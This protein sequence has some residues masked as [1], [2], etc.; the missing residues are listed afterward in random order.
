[1]FTKKVSVRLLTVAGATAL[2]LGVT[3]GTQAGTATANLTVQ[4]T[5]TSNC[6]IT[7]TAVD[8]G[9]YDP[10]VANASAALDAPAGGKV[11]LVCS[12][13]A[14]AK[15][16]LSEGA[17]PTGGSTAAAPARRLKHGTTDYLTYTLY[18]DA[19]K[20]N[21]WGDTAGTGLAHTGTGAQADLDVYGTVDGGQNVPV[22]TYT[23]TVVATVTF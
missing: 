17:N 22:G 5:V 12:N 18:S 6:T 8:F 1:M 4:A 14:A 21:V 15:V 10:I 19:G 23:D 20:Q 9:N 3:S 7:T 2:A 13:G 11:T 16:T